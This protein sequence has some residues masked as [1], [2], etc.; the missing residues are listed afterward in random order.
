MSLTEKAKQKDVN[1]RKTVSAMTEFIAMVRRCVMGV[2][3][4]Q[5][6]R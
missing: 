6:L 4:M 1:V 3:A 5:E 2:C